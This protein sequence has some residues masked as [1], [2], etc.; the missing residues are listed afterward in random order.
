MAIR[1]RLAETIV[2]LIVSVAGGLLQ[3]ATIPGRWEKVDSL[4]SGVRL[5]ITLKSGDT[6]AY[7]F[8]ES[9]ATTLTVYCIDGKELRLPKQGVARIVKREEQSRKADW[10]GAGIGAGGG[11]A[12]GL[13]ISQSFDETIFARG[14]V[15]APTFGAIGAAVGAIIG[16]SVG[17]PREEVVYQAP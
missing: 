13:I 4:A 6:E 7:R 12:V 9:D 8:K 16:H 10:I 11:V 2:F 15:M 1:F 14:D 3:G 5:V 17:K